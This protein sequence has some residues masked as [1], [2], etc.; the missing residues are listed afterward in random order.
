MPLCRE[1]DVV[2]WRTHETCP[3]CSARRPA[4]AVRT[5]APRRG[6][7]TAAV[8]TAGALL[9]LPALMAVDRL[10]LQLLGS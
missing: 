2:L 7:H 10:L 8:L 4:L 9:V 5:L 1:C 3:S 6:R